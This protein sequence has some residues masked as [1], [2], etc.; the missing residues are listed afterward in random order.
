MMK[1]SKVTMPRGGI[2]ARGTPNDD[3][4]EVWKPSSWSSLQPTSA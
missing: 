3:N 1:R 2:T 4:A